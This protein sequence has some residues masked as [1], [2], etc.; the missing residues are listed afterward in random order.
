MSDGFRVDMAELITVS[1]R[2]DAWAKATE[3]VNTLATNSRG[4]QDGVTLAHKI[5]AI[6][7]VARFLLGEGE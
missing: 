1:A 4:Y 6:E 7:R 5:D 2:E 3:Y